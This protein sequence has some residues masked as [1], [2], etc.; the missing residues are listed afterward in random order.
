MVAVTTQADVVNNIHG[1]LK[2]A[3]FVVPV[4]NTSRATTWHFGNRVDHFEPRVFV[5]GDDL[6]GQIGEHQ[7]HKE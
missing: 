5:T 1:K 4:V 2:I 3:A 6:C 7:H